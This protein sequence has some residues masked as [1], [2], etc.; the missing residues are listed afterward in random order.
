MYI[1]KSISIFYECIR[2]YTSVK[3]NR[4]KHNYTII[5]LYNS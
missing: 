3:L 2:V 5:E 1:P 4:N